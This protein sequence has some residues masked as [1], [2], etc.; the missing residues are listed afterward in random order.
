MYNTIVLSFA[1]RVQNKVLQKLM[2]TS[3]QILNGNEPED[4]SESFSAFLGLFDEVC[5]G[6]GRIELKE[7]GVISEEG[8]LYMN[9]EGKIFRNH[10][11]C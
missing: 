9:S 5:V 6:L 11:F 3:C 2:V 7:L 8:I 1:Y 10:S 4:Q